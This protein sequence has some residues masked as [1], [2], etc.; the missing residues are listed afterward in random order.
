MLLHFV[1]QKHRIE[2]KVV[3]NALFYFTL[4]YFILNSFWQ[5]VVY[6][7]SSYTFAAVYVE[8]V[9][10][11]FVVGRASCLSVFSA[12]ALCSFVF[13]YPFSVRNQ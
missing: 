13:I 3:C 7:I 2:T 9:M 6:D 8:R 12:D 1:C 11:L 10:F 4:P 5:R